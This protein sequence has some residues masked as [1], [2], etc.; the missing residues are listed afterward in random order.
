MICR[1]FRIIEVVVMGARVFARR[2]DE[3]MQ[4]GI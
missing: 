4:R 1:W 3:F 2:L